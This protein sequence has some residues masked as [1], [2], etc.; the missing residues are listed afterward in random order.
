MENITKRNEEW[1]QRFEKDVVQEVIERYNNGNAACRVF[2]TSAFP[3]KAPHSFLSSVFPTLS[4]V[5]FSTSKTQLQLL[6]QKLDPEGKFIDRSRS[7]VI[8]LTNTGSETGF[9]DYV[10]DL[11]FI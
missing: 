1:N 3:V 2:E 5:T 7:K 11:Q 10:F 4:D 8:N 6:M 9:S